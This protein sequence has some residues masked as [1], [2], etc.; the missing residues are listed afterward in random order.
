MWWTKIYTFTHVYALCACEMLYTFSYEFSDFIM[1]KKIY[2][3]LITTAINFQNTFQIKINYITFY[4]LCTGKSRP[5]ELTSSP[6]TYICMVKRTTGLMDMYK[7]IGKRVNS[8]LGKSVSDPLSTKRDL[9]ISKLR[10]AYYSGFWVFL[11]WGLM[12]HLWYLRQIATCKQDITNLY[13]HDGANRLRSN[14]D[15]LLRNNWVHTLTHCH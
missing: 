6:L 14:P 5:F 13:N 12:S 10:A 1:Y 3:L 4:L 8:K 7:R 9:V 15:P 11:I 2:I